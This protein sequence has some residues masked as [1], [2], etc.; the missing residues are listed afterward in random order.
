LVID[1]VVVLKD[2]A[3]ETLQFISDIQKSRRRKPVHKPTDIP[4]LPR[5][6][7]DFKVSL[8]RSHLSLISR[9]TEEIVLSESVGKQKPKRKAL[10]NLN[11]NL[12]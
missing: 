8:Q 9:I 7:P 6:Y 4:I 10:A 1:L 11:P 5:D 12:N 3:N 2:S